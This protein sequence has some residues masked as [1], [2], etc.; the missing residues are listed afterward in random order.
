MT[1]FSKQVD[2]EL[3][4]EELAEM[5]AELSS[6]DQAEFFNTVALRASNWEKGFSSGIRQQ[7]A[8]VGEEETLNPAGRE[9]MRAIGEAVE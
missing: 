4:V 8:Y 7:L 3:A 9:L 2:V 1:I 5:F 6:F